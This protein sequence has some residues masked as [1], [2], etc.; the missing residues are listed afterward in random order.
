[1]A[2]DEKSKNQILQAL[3]ALSHTF[4][5]ANAS[6]A[7]RCTTSLALPRSTDS[8]DDAAAIPAKA[9][10]SLP[11]R[12]SLV[13]LFRSRSSKHD[14]QGKDD[15]EEDDDD[16]DDGDDA[17]LKRQSF[18]AVTPCATAAYEEKKG[19]W[20]WKP[21]CTLSHIGKQRVSCLFSVEVV[22]AQSLPP[23]MNGLLLTVVIRRKETRDG[24]LQ[25]MPACV[26]TMPA[27]VQKGAADF[28]ETLYVRCHLYCSGSGG[29]T[30]KPLKFE[31][32][33]FILSVVAVDTPELDLGQT[34]MD[35]S[36]FVN[37]FTDKFQ[38]GLC[39]RQWDASFPLA[40]KAK[41]GDL[42]VKLAFQIMEGLGLVV[43]S[44]LDAGEKTTYS[45]WSSSFAQKMSKSSSSSF[46]VMSPKMLRSKL[47][48]TPKMGVPMPDMK[49]IDN[50][51]L[52]EPTPKAD[53]KVATLVEREELEHKPE[54]V[55]V[56][57]LK[58]AAEPEPVGLKKEEEHKEPEPELQEAKEEE[59]KE[60]EPEPKAEDEKS[61]DSEQP[62][63]DMVDMDIEGQE[64]N[65]ADK[66]LEVMVLSA[67][68]NAA[69][70][71]LEHPDAN[72]KEV[73]EKSQQPSDANGEVVTIES[74]LPRVA[75][76]EE[77]TGE[78]PTE[79]NGQE[80][81]KNSLQLSLSDAEE[82]TGEYLQPPEAN[83]MEV[84]K[85]SL[86]L[87]EANEVEF[88]GEYLQPT[89]LK[90]VK[91]L[92][93]KMLFKPKMDMQTLELKNVDNSKVDEPT[94]VAEVRATT[95][96]EQK[97]PEHIVET[98][99]PKL[100]VFKD[101][102]EEQKVPKHKLE[103][104]EA[105]EEE[106]QKESGAK[107]ET[108]DEKS[109]DSELLD[110]DVVDKGIERQ[111][112]FEAEKALEVMLGGM[113]DAATQS[114]EQLVANMEE[115]IGEF[116]QPPKINRENVTREQLL[117]ANKE[118]V[119]KEPM[120]P[121]KANGEAVTEEPLQSS[122]AN[123]EEVTKESLQS[124]EASQEGV[125]GESLQPPEPN[126]EE[127]TRELPEEVTA[128]SLQ[129][130]EPNRVTKE[131]LQ[132]SKANGMELTGDSLQLLEANMEQVTK[133]SLQPSEANGKEVIEDSLQL[134]EQGEVKVATAK[135]SPRQIRWQTL[136]IIVTPLAVI[137]SKAL[138]RRKQWLNLSLELRCHVVSQPN[139]S[140]HHHFVQNLLECDLQC[141]IPNH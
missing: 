12:L 3:L 14:K 88:I 93:S 137:A 119:T 109:N 52:N 58:E 105:K 106:E 24:A 68:S 73:T 80:V 76:G 23:C 8:D 33:P 139:Q 115:V 141:T 50:F 56:E 128:V 107:L 65:E 70:K 22:A 15:G 131:S 16:T 43:N 29:D 34:S 81:T 98:V 51:K 66:A 138:A 84:A 71:S 47:L 27:R 101:G 10:P 35:F 74:L 121:S 72:G 20:S 17:L 41:G 57:Q 79:A 40:G 87:P 110:F 103:Q 120:K 37:E 32:Q 55:K 126:M 91:M 129:P 95:L 99:E 130:L 18:A 134:Q 85:E 26:Q 90:D 11:R 92:K 64:E 124:L 42:V 135:S 111:E 117:E 62:E 123:R 59:Q 7:A 83:G 38:Q 86:Q 44:Q 30:G 69:T 1:M 94:P 77:A 2:G 67:V 136:A 13:S 89:E 78:Q 61:I 82:V 48:F 113:S 21:S 25:I 118:G 133:E 28:N 60:L 104:V 127:M 75:N 19:V 132:S 5:H 9:P 140:P 125:G 46:I 63:F 97:E 45:S 122:D 49:D 102:E 100:G 112:E 39:P 54:E 116:L 114:V 4:Y 36:A 96:V 31:P 53:V 6:A 108:E